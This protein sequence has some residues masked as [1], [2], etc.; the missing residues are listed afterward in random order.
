M[1]KDDLYVMIENG[2]A[3][4]ARVILD[5]VTSMKESLLRQVAHGQKLSDKDIGYLSALES[6]SE[7]IVQRL[8]END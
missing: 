5:K 7:F 1:N 8:Y 3:L 4:E 2:K 6:V